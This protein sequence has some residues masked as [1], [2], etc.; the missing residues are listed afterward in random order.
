M[1]KHEQI[2]LRRI[3]ALLAVVMVLAGIVVAGGLAVTAAPTAIT[4]N[5]NTAAALDPMAPLPAQTC[6]AGC[7]LYADEGTIALPDGGTAPIWGFTDTDGGTASVPG[8]VIIVNEGETFAVEFT[9]NI[10]NEMISLQ[11]GGVDG[12]VPDLTGIG[13]GETKTY[14]FTA[15]TPG[16]FR[17]EAG[18]TPNGGRQVMMGLFGAFIVRPAT[19]NQA[20]NDVD[21]AYDVEALLIFH[22]LDP[23]FNADPNNTLVQ[24]FAPHYRFINGKAYNDTEMIS[25]APGDKVLLRY[26]NAGVEERSMGVLGLR[27]TVIATDGFMYPYS[28]RVIAETIGAG[29]TKDMLVEIPSPV[30][31]GQQYSLYNTGV[32]Q[33]HNNGVHT[34]DGS[35]AFGGI[36][37]YFEVTGGGT[38]PAVGPLASNVVVSPTLTSG[39]VDLEVDFDLNM[40]GQNVTGYRVYLGGLGTAVLTDTV[41]VPA[42]A[43]SVAAIIPAAELTT[44]TPGQ[45]PVYVQGQAAD[46]T[47]GAVNSGFFE[48]VVDGPIITSLQ[49]S[50][51]PVNGTKDVILMATADS[52]SMGAATVEAAEYFLVPAGDLPGADGTGTAFTFTGGSAIANLSLDI[53]AADLPAIE[54]EYDVYVH[55]QDSLGNWGGYAT[56][57]L[58]VD[59]TGPAAIG[60]KLWPSPNN[61]Y[62]SVNSITYGV[63]LEIRI[64]D[65]SVIEDAEM[66]FDATIPEGAGVP[67]IAKDALFNSNTENAYANISLSTVRSWPDGVNQVYFRALDAAGNWGAVQS[68]PLVIDKTGPDVTNINVTPDPAN[69]SQGQIGVTLTADATDPAAG[70]S[71]I[72]T[73][74]WF[75]G[76]D[77]GVGNGTPM[78]AVD[79][80]FDIPGESTEALTADINVTRWRNGVYTLYVRAQDTASNWSPV[81]ASVTIEVQGNNVSVLFTD[82]FETNNFVGWTNV[83]GNVA[84]TADAAMTGNLGFEAQLLGNAPSYLVGQTPQVNQGSYN[85]TFQFNPTTSSS[86]TGGQTIFIAK[87]IAGNGIFGLTYD[88]VTGGAGPELAVFV[89]DG[90]LPGEKSAGSHI[91]A[92]PQDIKMVWNADAGTLEF[93]VNGVPEAQLTGASVNAMMSEIVLGPSAGLNAGAT[94]VQYYDN[95]VIA[96]KPFEIFLPFVSLSP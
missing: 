27:Q 79:G 36:Y 95:F 7:A 74:E 60:D 41:A 84:V 67:M 22:E 77:P 75:V 58:T 18:L 17:Y 48:L 28:Y 54:G 11:F 25:V 1:I 71:G 16:T 43:V 62:L 51:N 96:P 20:Y 73:A 68:L 76:V 87:D 13:F 83:V 4:T 39:N 6:S 32:V 38:A 19:A 69:P 49:M 57:K 24:H 65:F 14:T 56:I 42:N 82:G 59:K 80:A 93:F 66:F 90:L 23:D 5:A 91:T 33:M 53:L 2:S 12:L 94:G 40:T 63:R 35:V 88:N 21:S 47:W 44:L 89:N 29:E 34:A 10:T 78:Q 64:T 72:K 45:I 37:T 92:A 50:A 8:P 26:L 61:G 52:T 9:N 30:M 55:A 85:I 46:G 15:S 81:P 3:A 31:D 86:G 70:G